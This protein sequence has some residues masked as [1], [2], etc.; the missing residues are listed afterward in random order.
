M[1]A[2]DDGFTSI[3]AGHDPIDLVGPVGSADAVKRHATGARVTVEFRRDVP[4]GVG[5]PVK[6]RH[7]FAGGGDWREYTGIP[8]PTHT[9]VRWGRAVIHHYRLSYWL[10]AASLMDRAGTVARPMER[11]LVAVA[12]GPGSQP[13]NEASAGDRFHS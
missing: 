8:S 6:L 3:S 9:E 7:E 2:I 4:L 12:S 5:E 13:A 11:R 1:I 10:T